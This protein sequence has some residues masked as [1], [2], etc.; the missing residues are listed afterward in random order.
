MKKLSLLLGLVVFVMGTALSQRSISGTII[1]NTG[2]PL[3]GANVLVKGTTAGTITDID[4]NFTLDVPEGANELEVSYTGF[5]SQTINID[6]LSRVDMTLSE[7]E[8]LD[9]IVVTGLGIKKERKALG[10][11]VTTLGSADVELKPEADVARV[12]R[13]K[14]PGVDITS[15]SGLSGSGTNV[16]IR[17]YSSI[18][19]DN[20]PL[21][22]VDGVPFNSDT[23][24]DRGF[25]G[26]GATAS[27]RFLDLD[28][29]N[30]AEVSVL[31]G[32]SATV[33]YGEA[34]RNGVV[35]VTTKNG[36]LGELNKGM[37]ITLS[38]SLFQTEA[39]SIPDDQDQYGNGW[40]NAAA[41]AFSNWGAPFDQPGKN[42]VSEEG[43]INHPY[44]GLGASGVFPDY[45]DAQYDYR[46]YDNLGQFFQTGLSS[47][48][49]VNIASQVAEN[50]A[51]N[52]S[53]GFLND[54]GFTPDRADGTSSDNLR[55]HN[56][57]M[58]INTKLENGLKLTGTFNFITSERNTPPATPIYSSNPFGGGAS[59]F[60]NVLYTPR[61]VDL[62]GLEWENPNTNESIY[63]RPDNIIQHP[64]WTVNNINDKENVNRFF[65]TVG[66]NYA[67]TDDLMVNY[68]LGLD[69]YTQGKE[70]TVNKGGVQIQD[71]LYATSDRVNFLQDHNLNFSYLRNLTEQFDL[72]LL[73]GANARRET[74]DFTFVNSTEQFVY[75]LF[76][77][78][79][80]VNGIRST[81]FRE[82]NTLGLYFSGTFGF[83]NYLYLNLQGRN[84]WT[85][86]LE[87]DNRSIFYPSASVSF[88][89]SEAIPAL[90]NNKWVNYLKLRLGYG[91]SAGYPN[92][93][94]TRSTLASATNA[95]VTNGGTTLNTNSVSNILGNE[96]LKPELHKE[97]EFGM[98]ARFIENRLGVDL[99]L[100]N[101]TS[102]D[103]I[104]ALLLDPSTGYDETTVNAA[105]VQ[106]RG[107]ELGLN[108]TPLKNKDFY[109][110]VG[111]NFT[112][113][114][115]LILALDPSL[116]QF[117]IPDAGLSFLGNFAVAPKE[118]GGTSEVSADDFPFGTVRGNEIFFPYGVIIG[119]TIVRD[120]ATG[121]PIVGGDG[122]YQATP[123]IGQIG[124]PNPDFKT[125]TFGNIAYKGVG[126][127]VQFDYTRG[128]DIWA[129]TPSTLYS[130]GILKESGEFDRFV[131]VVVPG[132]REVDDGAGGT[133]LVENN[134]QVTPNEHFWRDAGVWFDENR[135]FDGTNLRLR[136]ISLS[137]D[138]PKSL[139][140][141]LPFGSAS[142]VLS[143]QN[144]WYKSFNI[145]AGANFDPEVLSL[146]VGNGQGFDFVTGPTAKKIGGTLRVTF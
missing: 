60:S 61:S 116:E 78:D 12:L 73:V 110:N 13:G 142:L 97:T 74:R 64:L 25:G 144:L 118:I 50:A 123:D 106:N 35:L 75:G 115:N 19:G 26:G 14:V 137:Y 30:I 122:L 139:L 133:M 70:Y 2:L 109:L 67:L 54:E 3:I 49:S 57:G 83:N 82:E 16:I 32:L 37:E 28:P 92:P 128:G 34:G 127:R 108:V 53:Y 111:F 56:F 52:F 71:G 39:A 140:G 72:D 95:F 138:I 46:A 31:K 91:T 43:T 86:T 69:T 84:D 48:T 100:Y 125:T 114:N 17:G 129:S 15:T 4:G 80:F 130:R 88:I 42:G 59:L 81:F 134:I 58:G 47:M 62:F 104:I 22:I 63:Y 121:R 126:F 119:Q 99:S 27:S 9:E 8:L 103:L 24:N 132:L 51:M 113:N 93:Y 117:L 38:Q 90:Q 6:G 45:A 65:G 102:S 131:P 141:S 98:E 44:Q 41:G 21:F 79:N 33:L 143:G 87:A 146:G 7:G 96:T 1:D 29:N 145:P 18:T 101:K 124:D 120:E 55:K 89:A 40:Q 112:K 20:Q 5:T 10:Y 66:L 68:K 76:T 94:R 85:S 136:E 36:N 23:N 107:I 11:G 77:H 105:E 135:I